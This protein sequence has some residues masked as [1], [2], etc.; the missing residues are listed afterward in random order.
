MNQMI[1]D[2]I[3][4]EFFEPVDA[5]KKRVLPF[6]VNEPAGVDRRHWP[7]RGG[8]PIPR[9][10]L[11]DASCI[12]LLDD[13]GREIPV[14]G[15]KIAMWPAVEFEEQVY[16]ESIQWLQLSFV[17]DLVGEKDNSFVLEYGME[18]CGTVRPENPVNVV[19]D[20][21]QIK[22]SNGKITLAL[23]QAERFVQSIRLGDREV[24]K[25]SGPAF[26]L[27][28]DVEPG[29]L[30]E[31]PIVAI[32]VGASPTIDGRLDDAAWDQAKSVDLHDLRLGGSPEHPTMGKLLMDEENLYIGLTCYDSDMDHLQAPEREHDSFDI[33]YD[34]HII[35]YIDPAY[36]GETRRSGPIQTKCYENF[37]AISVS[38]SGV[39]REQLIHGGIELW[40]PEM[41][42][43][44]EGLYKTSV[45]LE[46][47]GMQIQT[48][49]EA[50]R[51]TV[52]M[53][54]PLDS[55][56][57]DWSWKGKGEW[58]D[59]S[60]S[61]MKDPKYKN[62][63]G[64]SLYRHRAA[65]ETGGSSDQRWPFSLSY[66]N[67]PPLKMAR[68]PKPGTAVDDDPLSTQVVSRALEKAQVVVKEMVIEEEG[69]VE[70][71]VRVCGEYQSQSA[72]DS[73]FTMRFH[74]YA[75]RAAIQCHHT[76]HVGFGQ[77]E[78][79]LDA[80]GFELK[81]SSVQN[82]MLGMMD[83]TMIPIG[84]G[85]EFVQYHQDAYRDF[86]E[87]G[88]ASK[89]GQLQGSLVAEVSGINTTVAASAFWEKFPSGF[90][91]EED[92]IVFGMFSRR[93]FPLFFGQS[94]ELQDDYGTY[95]PS[96]QKLGDPARV[97][98][99][100][101]FIISFENDDPIA[102]GK[103]VRQ[104]VLPFAGGEWNCAS[105]ACGLMAPYDRALFPLVE[106]YTDY[107][108]WWNI[109]ETFWRGWYGWGDY[110]NT[111]NAPVARIATN[112]PKLYEW[113]YVRRG[114]YGWAADRKCIGL[115]YMAAWFRSGRRAW[116]DYGGALLR[117]AMDVCATYPVPEDGDDPVCRPRRHPQLAWSNPN[118]VAARQGGQPGWV[119]Y[120]L[121]TGDLRARDVIV[122]HA[123]QHVG[124]FPENHLSDSGG[125]S[126]SSTHATRYAEYRHILNT[127]LITGDEDLLIKLQAFN[128]IALK[129][130]LKT[131]K[132]AI[133]PDRFRWPN[134]PDGDPELETEWGDEMPGMGH[135]L[136]QWEGPL[137]Y[138][139]LTGD[140][141]M[142]KVV[143][144][145][146]G[147]TDMERPSQLEIPEL[148][149]LMIWSN[150]YENPMLRYADLYRWTGNPQ[151]LAHVAGVGSEAELLSGPL[152]TSPILPADPETTIHPSAFCLR[153]SS[154]PRLPVHYLYP[155]GLTFR[156]LILYT[157]HQI[158]ERQN[159]GK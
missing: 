12:R 122:M 14:Q 98:N 57:A 53:A 71:V 52:E 31:I 150:G 41:A 79:R 62:T 153:M 13:K 27:D 38:A 127:W 16:P 117:N 20:D 29:A 102:I 140:A 67:C 34:D 6:V 141:E 86:G 105:K 5:V 92:R 28:L 154:L 106:D 111:M 89:G 121:L 155:S 137:R 101:D 82:A 113:G 94:G 151:L 73:A 60:F 61:F 114:G 37:V 130:A 104:R 30:D 136:G 129:P 132:W 2:E 90:S 7:V 51:W 25:D 78:A 66:M 81:T 17:A 128:E 45:E 96:E 124:P 46:V 84:T 40:D 10:E 107:A 9:G 131:G 35:V 143:V 115:G 70:T 48:A 95:G 24:F 135:E 134:V 100:H 77:Y 36:I 65:R 152:T 110:G 33:R 159:R 1:P 32:P 133:R 138:Y 3:R 157:L 108:L 123:R 103:A 158:A 44:T 116:F 43:K 74:M 11:L 56:R 18:V 147:G 75:D 49:R 55:V 87:F 88:G 112:H 118:G 99:T 145:M 125:T 63:F 19:E 91:V 149:K 72:R 80:Y 54:I 93:A 15:R 126:V 64:L 109:N 69:P 50:D 139:Q 21:R 83:G 85:A 146:A 120:Y 47:P 144:M 59:S 39:V 58:H 42:A 8:I 23:T 97:N 156:P 119:L 26:S 22:V 76:V 4:P 68:I 148:P 142:G